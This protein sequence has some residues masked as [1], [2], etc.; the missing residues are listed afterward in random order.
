MKFNIS[1]FEKQLMDPTIKT[2]SSMRWAFVR[3]NQATWV[4]IGAFIVV[5][6]VMTVGASRKGTSYIEL[7]SGLQGVGIAFASVLG[8]LQLAIQGG[9]VLSMPGEAKKDAQVQSTSTGVAETIK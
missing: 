6:L 3:G 9:K 2:V 1:D 8:A 7:G 4:L 5:T